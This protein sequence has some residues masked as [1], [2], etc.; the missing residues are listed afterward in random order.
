MPPNAWEHDSRIGP[1]LRWFIE[2]YCPRHGLQPRSF[3]HAAELALDELAR[4]A[5]LAS[6]G[7]FTP[8]SGALPEAVAA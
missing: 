2:G 4:R 7:P 1:N 3:E 5:A 6:V 8:P